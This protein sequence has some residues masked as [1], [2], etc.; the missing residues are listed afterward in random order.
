MKRRTRAEKELLHAK[1]TVTDAPAKTLKHKSQAIPKANSHSTEN[2]P[3]VNGDDTVWAKLGVMECRICGFVTADEAVYSFHGCRMRKVVVPAAGTGA[4]ATCSTFPGQRGDECDPVASLA[5]SS[6]PQPVVSESELKPQPVVFECQLDS[7]PM[8]SEGTPQPQPV[9]S[10]SELKPQPVVFECQLN[11]QPIVSEGTPQ[12]QPAASKCRVHHQQ[13]GTTVIAVAPVSDLDSS[14]RVVLSA[15]SPTLTSVSVPRSAPLPVLHSPPAT[16]FTLSASAASHET[17]SCTSEPKDA[18]PSSQSPST[19]SPQASSSVPHRKQK[20][21]CVGRQGFVSYS[22]QT[23]LFSCLQCKYKACEDSPL[24]EHLLFQMVEKPYQCVNCE[25][26]FPNRTA[27]E[28]HCQ[29]MHPNMKKKFQLK[30]VRFVKKILSKAREKAEMDQ[31]ASFNFHPNF[32]VCMVC[33]SSDRK[34]ATVPQATVKISPAAPREVLQSS[35]A[36]ATP[37]ASGT[38]R[39]LNDSSSVI[40][41][42]EKGR[43][44][45]TPPGEAVS[46]YLQDSCPGSSDSRDGRVNDSASQS[47]A[48]ATDQCKVTKRHTP[49]IS[50]IISE[51]DNLSHAETAANSW[52]NRTAMDNSS[53]V[54]Q[55]ADCDS[56]EPGIQIATHCGYHSGHEEDFCAEDLSADQSSNHMEKEGSSVTDVN[57]VAAA[58][59]TPTVSTFGPMPASTSE[60]PDVTS[61]AKQAKGDHT[62]LRLK[63][64]AS[65][66]SGTVATVCPP[67][68]SV[69]D[70]RSETVSVGSAVNVRSETMSVGSAVNVRSETMSVGSAVNVRSEA[71]SV[72][73]AVNVRSETMSVGSAVNVRSETV[74]VGSAVNV[75]SETVSVGSVPVSDVRS[76]TMSVGSAVNVRSETMSVGSVPMSD[77]R[78]ETVSV[79][80][81]PMC[82]VRSETMSVGSVPV[83]DVRSETQ[84][85]GSVPVS[86]VRSETV[87]VGSVPVSDVRSETQ[88]VGSVPVSDVRSETMS[89]GSVP[90]SDVRSET[91]SVGSVPVSD[92]RSETM[93]VGSVPVSDVRSETV[94]VGSVPMSDVRSETV[95]VGSVPMSDVRS[96]TVSVGS[97]PV[98][99]VRSETQSVGSVPV[100]DVRSETVSVGSV[101]VS[102]ARSETMSV[103][104]VPVSDVRSETQSVG[105]VPVSDVRSETQSVGS[106]PVSDVRSETQSVGSVPVS[107]VR[108]ETML[109]G[110]AGNVRSETVSMGSVPVIDVRSKTFQQLSLSQRPQNSTSLAS[111]TRFMLQQRIMMNQVQAGMRTQ[112]TGLAFVS[113][114]AQ[115]AQPN[116][117]A[118]GHA[119]HSSVSR[120]QPNQ[121]LQ[122]GIVRTT[123]PAH[124]IRYLQGNGSK[125]LLHIPLLRVPRIVSNENQNTPVFLVQPRHPTGNQNRPAFQV[126]QRQTMENQNR[127][128][129]LQQ[130]SPAGRRVP[131]TLPLRLPISSA[132][133]PMF[134]L[135]TPQPSCTSI[136]PVGSSLTLSPSSVYLPST[137]R[138]DQ[139]SYLFSPS[140]MLLTQAS[141]HGVNSTTP[142]A[143]ADILQYNST[144]AGFPAQ[145]NTYSQRSSSN[146][147]VLLPVFMAQHR[148]SLENQT[149]PVLQVPQGSTVESQNKAVGEVQQRQT[150]GNQYRT[151]VS[152]PHPLPEVRRP[153][154]T[155]PTYPL[156]SLPSPYVTVAPRSSLSYIQ[157]AGAHFF[158]SPSFS[159]HLVCK[160]SNLS[161][162]QLHSP[163]TYLPQVSGS[164]EST[165]VAVT[166]A[167]TSLGSGGVAA[168]VELGSTTGS[169]S[170][171][172]SGTTCLPDATDRNQPGETVPVS[173]LGT[174]APGVS[175]DLHPQQNDD[176]VNCFVKCHKTYECL[177]CTKRM[178]DKDELYAHVWAHLHPEEKQCD[179]FCD[180]STKQCTLAKAAAESVSLLV[181]CAAPAQ[182]NN[183]TVENFTRQSITDGTESHLATGESCGDMSDQ[184]LPTARSEP[185]KSEGKMDCQETPNTAGHHESLHATTLTDTT[186]RNG[187]LTHVESSSAREKEQ[188]GCSESPESVSQHVGTKRCTSTEKH[189]VCSKADGCP[190]T[191]GGDEQ[192]PHNAE[193]HDTTLATGKTGT[194]AHGL[195]EEER[196]IAA[197]TPELIHHDSAEDAGGWL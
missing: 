183:D 115:N 112:Q 168:S 132:S 147:S 150:V 143:S 52:V 174:Q 193:D 6:A 136:E 11:A 134:T 144:Q 146:S 99:D 10:E 50:S 166:S 128:I 141:G 175:A 26:D 78:S 42:S 149:K 68:Q 122:S 32:T 30:S 189:P 41:A 23:K 39:P 47:K 5:V 170:N 63:D 127:M 35:A 61:V 43:N 49:V 104:S 58:V 196:S 165:T 44:M 184:V 77:F 125:S 163:A 167:E 55:Q 13:S 1:G 157:P 69:C 16:V 186:G 15:A 4:P 101:P 98:S 72:G 17:V 195:E 91:Q 130:E 191:F 62:E 76:E 83:S 45:T 156:V 20:Q 34:C 108:S 81:V 25:G 75:R 111:S 126:Q 27:F 171:V 37:A 140:R 40:E 82:D 38:S 9:V 119:G 178:K 29:R 107:D 8:V 48:A 79:G 177:M 197:D 67:A 102:D 153:P 84:S 159:S 145:Q 192:A 64:G 109:V 2:H 110:S 120:I 33:K 70:V 86:D 129:L 148:V 19:S 18:I 117:T 94:S 88:S 73:S 151:V 194:E 66:T 71:M 106:V 155:V 182:L 28:S 179:V 87:S 113:P 46:A 135:I 14:R 160:T 154:N 131:H 12:P 93:S 142:S 139:L 96:E 3:T 187:G 100:S 95:S 31:P 36:T 65:L 133:T 105:S 56:D 161:S 85:V 103:G 190:V 89:V 138:S 169:V 21:T 60:T 118:R 114:S 152:Q 7:Q 124:Q 158:I 54:H 80:S 53:L 172:A 162:N 137:I 59:D 185:G 51:K 188:A 57:Q 164:G 116:S 180:V 90:V 181:D 121:I 97:V 74:S 176:G 173:L 92:V 123:A 24:F 22:K